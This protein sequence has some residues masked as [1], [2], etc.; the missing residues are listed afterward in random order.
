MKKKILVVDDE[1]SICLLLQNFL[2]QDYEIITIHDPIEALQWLD[3]SLPDLIISDIQMTNMD[4]YEFLTKVRQRGFTKHTPFIMLSGKS[5]SKERIKCYRLGA[6]DYLTKPFNP[7]EL[8]ELVKK[9]IY[10]IHFA[11]E[12]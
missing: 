2:S 5:E 8:E 1:I 9:N 3:E 4:G 11:I 7:E 10:P 6:Q 12:W